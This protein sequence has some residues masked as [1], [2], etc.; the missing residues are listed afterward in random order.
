MKYIYLGTSLRDFW[1]FYDNSKHSVATSF[2]EGVHWHCGRLLGRGQDPALLWQHGLLL[3]ASQWHSWF[4]S[5]QNVGT[6]V[7]NVNKWCSFGN[8][9]LLSLCSGI[10]L[11]C[12]TAAWVLFLCLPKCPCASGAVG[13]SRA[14]LHLPPSIF[15]HVFHAG[16][17]LTWLGVPWECFFQSLSVRSYCLSSLWGFSHS[18][19]SAAFLQSRCELAT[20]GSDSKAACTCSLCPFRAAFLLHFP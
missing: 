20:P 14:S 7:E 11:G 8:S 19:V 16:P 13:I 10:Y 5:T 9:V 6:D 18:L 15:M 12:Q 1:C 4:G 17:Q 2:K 3:H